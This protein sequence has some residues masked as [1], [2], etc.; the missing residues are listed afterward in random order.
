[1]RL[2]G[3]AR[4][5]DCES[6]AHEEVEGGHQLSSRDSLQLLKDVHVNCSCHVAGA[7]KV[8][9]DVHANASVTSSTTWMSLDFS[10]T[11]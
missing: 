3:E 11:Q 9:H 8:F 5:Q 7:K 6:P 1:M 10:R 2:Q 4:Q